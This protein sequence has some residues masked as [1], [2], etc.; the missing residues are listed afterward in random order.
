LSES[1]WLALGVGPLQSP[2]L[3]LGK[4]EVQGRDRASLTMNEHCRTGQR[5]FA[6]SIIRIALALT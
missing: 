4:L 3:F 6:E 1:G 5:Q 2:D